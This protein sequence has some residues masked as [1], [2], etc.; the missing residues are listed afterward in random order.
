M[1]VLLIYPQYTHSSEFDSRAPSMSLVYL[2]STLEHYG[3]TVTIYDASLGPIVKTGKVFRYGISEEEIYD[4]LKSQDFDIVGITCSFVS[5]WRFV[6]KIAQQVKEVSPGS[7]VVIGGLFPTYSW[8]YCLNNCKAVDII[9][10]GEAELTFAEIV[11][12]I[13]RGYSISDSC[14]NVDGVVWRIDEILCNSKS[15]YNDNLDDLLFPA[16]HLV[17]LKKYFLL[18]KKIYELPPPSLPILSSRSC[19]YR[20]NFCNMYITH[21]P[22]W[23]ARSSENV[24]NEIE[25]LVKRFNVH[26]FYFIDDNFSVNPKRAKDICRG[27]IERKLNIKYNFHNGLSIKTID[28]ELVQLMKKSGCTSVCLGI[29]SGSERIRNGVYGKNLS[30]EKVIEVFNLFHKVKIPTIGFFMVGAPGETRADFEK[31]KELLIKLPMSLAT[32]G[33]YT[34]YPGTKLYDECKERGWLIESSPDDPE[35]VE[36]FSGMLRTP[37]FGPEDVSKWKKELYLTFIRYHWFTLLKEALRPWGVVNLDM[38]GKFIGAI[39]FHRT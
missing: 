22:T 33:N 23:R 3:H 35:R 1:R 13:S 10:L 37:D 27:I 30:T 16:W 8:E 9:M 7:P 18:Q 36:M 29:E 11:N 21:G 4:F 20:C 34:P 31:T 38:F 39:K 19:P 25:Y 5:R 32:V 2:A 26:N 28:E 15:K 14:K 6:A 12:N 24:L 17:D